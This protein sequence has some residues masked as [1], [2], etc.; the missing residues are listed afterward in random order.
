M[1]CVREKKAAEIMRMKRK[2]AAMRLKV[3]SF[4]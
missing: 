1:V 4:V 2:T 3:R